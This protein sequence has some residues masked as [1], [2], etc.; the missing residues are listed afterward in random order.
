MRGIAISIGLLA[1]AVLTN[2]VLE[3]YGRE[4]WVRVTERT[5]LN[6]ATGKLVMLGKPTTELYL[7]DIA[8]DIIERAPSAASEP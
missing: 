4:R 5:Y 7:N 8:T 1:F 2:A 3:Y 6:S